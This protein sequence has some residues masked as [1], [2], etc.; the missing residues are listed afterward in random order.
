MRQLAP[1]LLTFRQA[2][3]LSRAMNASVLPRQAAP[4]VDRERR[5]AK[6]VHG[7]RTLGLGLGFFPVAA[8]FW[9]NGEPS[10]LWALL[11]L[12]GFAW[13]HLARWLAVR[14]TTPVQAEYRNLLVDSLMGGVWV[15]LMRF[16]LL[17]SVALL[18]MLAMD[19]LSVGGPRLLLRGLLLQG[20]ACALTAA[21]NGWALAAHTDVTVMLATLPFMVLYP[22]AISTVM[23]ALARQVRRQNHQLA[24]ISSTDGLSDLLNRGA[25][26]EAVAATLQRCRHSGARASLLMID[27][28]G[29]KHINDRHGHPAGD[30]VIGRVGA[31]IRRCMRDT[32]RAGRYGGDEFGVL[33]DR[34]DTGAAL[35][36]AER[37]RAS[38]ATA[39]F[40]QAEGMHCTLSIG[41]AE[42]TPQI[43]DARGWIKRADDALYRAK[44]DG[45]NRT[46]C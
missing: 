3:T 15:A 26:E 38:V 11:L 12:N 16:N 22:L 6:R 13:P 27:I 20:I 28:D 30:A 37:I 44:I 8:V 39:V 34:A 31:I 7:L 42:I 18:T 43:H 32:D 21:A 14:S 23:H 33:L 36:I 17:P 1:A 24:R 40:E 4:S 9:Q 10:L 25:W 2:R 35:A 46:A 29:F 5:F 41:V 19:K 45:R